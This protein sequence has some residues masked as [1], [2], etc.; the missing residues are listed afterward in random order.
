VLEFTIAGSG[1]TYDKAA[2]SHGIAYSVILFSLQED[3]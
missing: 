3:G 1:C 2:I